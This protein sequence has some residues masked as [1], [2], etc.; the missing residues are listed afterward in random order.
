[1]IC[2]L[3]GKGNTGPCPHA[4]ENARKAAKKMKTESERKKDSKKRERRDSTESE[5]ETEDDSKQTKRKRALVKKVESSLK[6]PELKVFRG[7]RVPFTDDQ[8]ATV[9][10]QFLRATISA[11]L[12]F[13]WV[14][15]PEVTKLFLLFRSTAGDVIPSRIQLAGKILDEE[16][17]RVQKQLKKQV[18]GQYAVVSSDGWKD[19]SRD[20]INGVSLSVAGKVS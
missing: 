4:S 18:K 3:L 2:H 14:E 8:A 11:N 16:N 5:G 12:P 13:C 15:D 9:H 20:S 6:Q 7:I 10:Q 17:E 19:V 1:M